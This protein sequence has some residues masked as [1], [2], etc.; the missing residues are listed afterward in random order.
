[1][2]RSEPLR[3]GDDLY[4]FAGAHR[5][6]TFADAIER[7]TVRDKVL[8]RKLARLQQTHDLGELVALDE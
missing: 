4:R 5:I 8:Q 2:N 6:N 3:L 7:H 1:M